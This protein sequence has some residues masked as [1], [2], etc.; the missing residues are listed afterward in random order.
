VIGCVD[1]PARYID[2][3]DGQAQ[4]WR[5]AY[6]LSGAVQPEVRAGVGSKVQFDFDAYS[7][8]GNKTARLAMRDQVGPLLAIAQSAYEPDAHIDLPFAISWG[9]SLAER[10]DR[11]CGSAVLRAL[12]IRGD[13]E[14]VVA[15]GQIATVERQGRRYRFWNAVSIDVPGPSCPDVDSAVSWALWRE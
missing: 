6:R 12:S 4:T 14:V 10:K 15:P 11:T 9:P 2:V 5:L 13:K 7:P 1:G 3:V 8:A